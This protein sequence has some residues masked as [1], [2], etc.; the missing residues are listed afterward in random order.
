MSH[1][2]EV[3]MGITIYNTLSREKEDFIPLN[4]PFVG[5]YVCGPTV[6]GDSH[7]GHA[8]SYT[9]FDVLYRHLKWSGY[10]VRY[11]QNITDVGHLTGD[12]DDGSDKIAKQAVLER[13]EPVEIAYKYEVSYFDDMKKLNILNPDIS[14]RATGHII[15]MIEHIQALIEKGYAYVTDQ[16]NIYFEVRKFKDYGKLS[17]RVLEETKSGERINIAG[18]KRN[19]EDFALWKAAD[20]SHLMKWNSPWGVGYPGW[21]IECSVMSKKYIGETLDIHGGGIDNVFPHHECEIAQSEALTGKPF[22]RYFIH[23]NMLTVNGTKMGKSLGN[24]IILKD[25]FKEIEPMVLR[26]Y[27]LQ[28]HYR[29]V[30]DFS[31]DSMNAAKVGFDRMRNS[32]FSLYKKTKDRKS[33]GTF[34]DVDEIF[35]QFIQAM[36]DDFNTPIAISV[37]YELLKLSNTELNKTDS[38]INKLTYISEKITI[39]T[40]DILGIQF[41]TIEAGVK[42]HE[43][44]LISFLIEMRKQYRAEKNFK[45][46]DTIRDSLKEMGITLKDGAA[47]TAYTI[48]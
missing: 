9:V 34:R 22:I 13:K 12:T 3:H 15:E 16:N 30:L 37:I 11:V 33:E 32:I 46:S 45:M 10:K 5:M 36:D 42:N 29:S 6:Y 8:R 25:L 28:S 35:S 7:L 1:L 26:F 2:K 39:M 44:Q 4:P 38:D 19:S 14:C 17:G 47:E 20:N 21:H 31:K 41:N 40:D 24:F 23:N 48:D 18:D 27:I 43:D